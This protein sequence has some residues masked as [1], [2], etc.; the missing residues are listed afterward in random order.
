MTSSA[1]F[2]T[3]TAGASRACEDSRSLLRSQWGRHPGLRPCGKSETE[4]AADGAADDGLTPRI[5]R[6]CAEVAALPDH[7]GELRNQHHAPARD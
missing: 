6:G 5:C 7:P 4:D 3:V 2:S 1:A